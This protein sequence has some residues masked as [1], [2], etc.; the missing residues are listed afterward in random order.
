MSTSFVFCTKCAQQNPSTNQ[1]CLQC[2]NKLVVHHQQPNHPIQNY[3]QNLPVVADDRENKVKFSTVLLLVL[4]IILPAWIITL[5]L[6]W[7]F[8]YVSY[9]KP[10]SW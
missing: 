5:P 8:A 6:C 2:G 3:Q 4:G 7:Y 10:W 1:V 9:K